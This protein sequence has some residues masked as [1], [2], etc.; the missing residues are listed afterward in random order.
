MKGE[1]VKAAIESKLEQT[2]SVLNVLNLFCSRQHLGTQ[3]KV[4]L[5][6][7]PLALSLP[8]PVSS[9]FPRQASNPIHNQG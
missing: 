1:E 2:A 3:L 8:L 6:S 9:H 7:L 4:A 5:M